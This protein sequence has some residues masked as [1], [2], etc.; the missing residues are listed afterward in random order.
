MKRIALLLVVLVSACK[1]TDSAPKPQ[2]EATAPTP[3]ARAHEARPVPALPSSPEAAGSD[4]PQLPSPDGDHHWGGRRGDRLARMDKDGDGKISDEERQTAMKERSE[5]M[6][7]R[8]DSNNDGKLTPEEL[9][10]ANGRMHFDDPKALDLDHNGDISTEELEAGMKARRDEMRE[11]RQEQ[12]NGDPDGS[13][14]GH[15]G[16]VQNP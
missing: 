6:R 12:R 5:K 16:S 1:T 11:L 10:G 7:A 13:G 4:R 8:F 15:R 14:A 9:A 2:P 3:T